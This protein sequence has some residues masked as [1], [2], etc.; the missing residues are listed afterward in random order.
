[1]TKKLSFL[2]LFAAVA[3]LCAAPALSVKNA[4]LPNASIA[5]TINAAKFNRSFLGELV[6]NDIIGVALE[7]AEI[8]IDPNDPIQAQLKALLEKS[9][10]TF[11][12]ELSVSE[13]SSGLEPEKAVEKSMAC[14]EFPQPLGPLV[15]GLIAQMAAT[16]KDGMTFEPI[17]ING[18][19]GVKITDNKDGVAV[20]MVFSANGKC[21][22]LATPAT[23]TKQ[24]TEEAAAAAPAQLLAAQANAVDGFFLNLGIILTDEIKAMAAEASPEAAGFASTMNAL[25][26]S[27]SA[28]GELVNLK[29]GANF[30]TPEIAGAIKSTFDSEVL[31]M[32]QP[33]ASSLAQGS[34]VS[35]VN[36]LAC[37]LDGTQVNLTC[38]LSQNDI[39]T[40]MQIFNSATSGQ[41]ADDLD[42]DGDDEDEDGVEV[43]EVMSY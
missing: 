29:L 25:S 31:P 42:E 9:N 3:M 14:V 43:E 28:T 36:T 18:F 41:G 17:V 40:I 33:M 39:F 35:F 34:D 11:T 7:G 5:V 27:A 38:S 19:K 37:S 30:I 15:D 26:F 13:A 2:A 24:L 6:G 12:T 22:F 23:L 16:Q 1:M 32:V 21:L 4:Y 20:A 8:E 10:I